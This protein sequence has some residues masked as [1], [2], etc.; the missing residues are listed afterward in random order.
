VH[1]LGYVSC[2]HQEQEY[3]PPIRVENVG[4]APLEITISLPVDSHWTV[5]GS[6]SIIDDRIVH[7][8]TLS[9]T[10]WFD[11]P[12]GR[13]SQCCAEGDVLDTL[14]TIDSNDAAQPHVEVPV[15][16][17]GAHRRV[18]IDPNPTVV[19]PKV[20]GA[21]TTWATSATITN[22]GN[23]PWELSHFLDVEVPLWKAV[24]PF[25]LIGVDEHRVFEPG[26]QVQV[27]VGIAPLLVGA[28][29]TVALRDRQ[30]FDNCPAA[31]ETLWEL[32]SE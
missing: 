14:V 9:P 17:T 13:R 12:V 7:S 11:I 28:V 22:S 18:T 31:P 21:G 4:T 15:K 2:S 32:R 6:W 5:S 29:K 30:V 23:I 27:T 20:V 16:A 10:L 24:L 25:D 26:E 3:F 1:D 19:T 8:L